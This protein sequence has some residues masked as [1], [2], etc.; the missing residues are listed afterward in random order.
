[1]SRE[2]AMDA[3]TP[4]QAELMLRFARKPDR[5]ALIER[6]HFG[7]LVVQK[8]LY[9]EGPDVCHA[10]VIHPPGG[11]AGGDELSLMI[12]VDTGAHALVTTPAAGKWYKAGERLAR[13]DGTFTIADGAVLEWLPQES[14][15]FDAAQAT[16]TWKVDL[17]GD[18]AFAAWEITCLGRRASGEVF[19]RGKLRQAN[20]I[21]R[22]DTQIWGDL[23]SLNGGDPLMASPVGLGG[24]PVFGTMIVAAGAVP[25]E[26]LETC[27]EITADGAGYGVTALPEI[28]AA[29]YLGNSA[30]DAKAYFSKLWAMLRPWYGKRPAHRPRLWDT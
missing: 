29:R 1:M 13:Q 2:K 22:N 5:T 28:F 19:A 4:W 10:I 6:R 15:V 26:L 7:P 12:G 20:R 23:V 18:A 17:A 16:M 25:P 14:I 11:I 9:P 3:R 24:H 21:F 27:R 8:P 30:E